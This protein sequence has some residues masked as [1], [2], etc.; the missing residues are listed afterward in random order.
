MAKFLPLT[1]I[2]P[3]IPSM[4]LDKRLQDDTEYGLSIFK[5]NTGTYMNW[6][7][8]RPNGSAVYVSF[9]SLAELGVDQMEELAWGLG[10]SNCNF[11]W[12][13]RSKEE[14]KLLKDF[15]KETSEKGLVVSWC[16]SWCPQLQVLAHK[17]V[18]CL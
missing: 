13:V 15:V 4:F 3:T 2:A 18:G 6:L 11:L 12:V 14:A 16:P 5:P 7:K 9:G 17:A 8:E 10:D 1:S